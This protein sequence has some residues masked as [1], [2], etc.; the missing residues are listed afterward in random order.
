VEALCQ[1][2]RDPQNHHYPSYAGMEEY[3]VAVADWYRSRFGISLD[4]GREVLALMGSKDGIA[5]IPEAFV[6]P[7]DYVLAPSPGYPV[8]RT[9][10]LFAEGRVFEMPL[11]RER[12]FLPDFSAI[13]AD[14]VRGARLMFGTSCRTS[15]QSPLMWSGGPG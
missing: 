13:P 12:D 9:S 15:L 1:A 3:R 4:P 2:A 6:N 7:G 14:V 10:T 8:Y 5:H 11:R